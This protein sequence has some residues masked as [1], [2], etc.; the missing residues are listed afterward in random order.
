M[1]QDS[2]LET[3]TRRAIEIYNRTHSP[4]RKATLVTLSPPLLTIQFS[5]IFCTG[6]GTQ[7][8]TDGFANQYSALS[9]GKIELRTGETSQINPHTFQTTYN[10]KN[11]Q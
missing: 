2:S 1:L 9:G 11:K 6:C 5:G 10:I 3:L 8:I 7:D 4:S